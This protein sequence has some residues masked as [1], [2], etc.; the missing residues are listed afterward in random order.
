M[1]LFKRLRLFNLTTIAAIAPAMTFFAIPALAQETRPLAVVVN[2]DAVQMQAVEMALKQL[3]AEIWQMP[4]TDFIEGGSSPHGIQLRSLDSPDTL[5][6]IDGKSALNKIPESRPIFL[7]GQAVGAQSVAKLVPLIERPI[8]LVALV[9]PPTNDTVLYSNAVS[10]QVGVFLSY[11]Q[12]PNTHNDTDTFNLGEQPCN[13]DFGCSQF[14]DDGDRATTEDWIQA[15]IINQLEVALNLPATTNTAISDLA[16]NFAPNATNDSFQLTANSTLT[17]PS[18]GF[19]GNDNDLN[20]DPLNSPHTIRGAQNGTLKVYVDGSFEYTPNPDFVGTDSFIY[21]V[22]DG[23]NTAQ[24]E[25]T[26]SIVASQPTLAAQNDSFEVVANTLFSLQA[27]GI[28]ANDLN[29]EN[30]QLQ[31]PVYN[32]AG[33]NGTL[34]IFNGGGLQYTPNPGFIG[35]DSFT[36]T[37]SDGQNRSQARVTFNVLPAN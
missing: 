11:F 23:T 20:G 3:D 7:I 19:L 24:A 21:A 5:L 16:E 9:H 32:Y 17:I 13:P 34:V 26:L 27:P 25:V 14:S 35:T 22:S 15:D 8:Q 12:L 4:H 1:N 30:L 36:Y 28:L 33:Q 10:P 37:V 31:V 18:P 6:I 29:P 2:G